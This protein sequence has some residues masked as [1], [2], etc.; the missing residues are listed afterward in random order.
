MK[1]INKEIENRQ[2][3]LETTS[4]TSLTR[5]E[6]NSHVI[7]DQLCV[8]GNNHTNTIND[9]NNNLLNEKPCGYMVTVQ[10]NVES[11]NNAGLS[12]IN[13][14]T[15]MCSVYSSVK[16]AEK[17]N[18]VVNENNLRKSNNSMISALTNSSS[19]S[20]GIY[21]VE[22][23]W[24]QLRKRLNLDESIRA[25]A[26]TFKRDKG[27]TLSIIHKDSLENGLTDLK[28]MYNVSSL[29]PLIFG[30]FSFLDEQPAIITSNLVHRPDKPIFFAHVLLIGIGYSDNLRSQWMSANHPIKYAYV[31]QNPL[32]AYSVPDMDRM[33]V[34]NHDTNE[35]VN[36]SNVVK[37]IF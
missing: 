9:K 23:N 17:K 29:K 35:Q 30:M 21:E 15:S 4:N 26:E 5:M 37:E 1:E 22:N 16:L 19:S 27:R 7:E 3:I 34:L 10:P 14:N 32:M 18:S 11:V 25:I 36:L 2:V 28:Q 31:Q 6:V 24:K 33:T 13:E 12:S 8:D 20:E